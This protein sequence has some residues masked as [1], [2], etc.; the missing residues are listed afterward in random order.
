MPGL[1]GSM[2]RPGGS[3]AAILLAGTATTGRWNASDKHA[4]IT[5]SNSNRTATAAAPPDYRGVRGDRGLDTTTVVPIYAEIVIDNRGTGGT[6]D[7]R[8]GF[9]NAT[10][11]LV[12]STGG[13]LIFV[14]SVGTNRVGIRGSS[15]TNYPGV[16]NESISAADTIQMLFYRKRFWWGINGSLSKL[17]ISDL[18]DSG[19]TAK[20]HSNSHNI[21]LDTYYLFFSNGSGVT[22]Q[23]SIP[24]VTGYD[25]PPGALVY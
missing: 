2:G 25:A 20:G 11:S 18:S 14:G 19:S 10:T 13:N 21:T 1:I 9:A 22:P 8:F 12:D 6:D 15:G 3:G 16:C 7:Y 17:N 23:V 5:L 4:Q 24:S